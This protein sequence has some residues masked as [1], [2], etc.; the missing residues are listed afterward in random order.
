[1]KKIISKNGKMELLLLLQKMIIMLLLEVLKN[2]SK[3]ITSHL[4][5]IQKKI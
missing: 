1:M 4:Q 3:M 5:I 2:M